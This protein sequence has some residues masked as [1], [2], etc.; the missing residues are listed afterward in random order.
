V[1]T[2]VVRRDKTKPR[3]TGVGVAHGRV[4]KFLATGLPVH[5]RCSEAAKVSLALVVARRKIASGSGSLKTAGKLSV[6]LQFS[7]HARHA[8]G[9]SKPHHLAAMLTVT[10]TDRAGNRSTRKVHVTLK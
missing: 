1:I 5:L 4:G 6:R 2:L 10:A 3:C 7:K 9:K 8:L